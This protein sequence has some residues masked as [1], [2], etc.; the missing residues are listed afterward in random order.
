MKYKLFFPIV[1]CWLTLIPVYSI[2]QK[3]LLE[4]LEKDV[5]QIA[6]DRDLNDQDAHNALVS[7]VTRARTLSTA[8]ESA[9][10]DFDDQVRELLGRHLVWLEKTKT[11]RFEAL[12]YTCY[13]VGA[14][15]LAYLIFKGLLWGRERYAQAEEALKA[16][17]YSINRIGGAGSGSGRLTIYAPSYRIPSKEDIE[18]LD[19]ISY[20]WDSAGTDLFSCIIG[21]GIS[22]VVGG[23][24]GLGS[25]GFLAIAVVGD[26]DQRAY[27]RLNALFATYAVK[28]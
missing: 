23:L 13:C 4:N 12:K 11:S 27:D 18:N 2:D 8:S 5:L 25:L 19:F 7:I 3:E 21:G 28:P 17:G 15:G 1:F 20:H 22:A 9:A 6:Q 10:C 26:K 14:A 16:H 24:S